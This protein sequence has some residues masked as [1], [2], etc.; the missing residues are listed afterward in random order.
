MIEYGIIIVIAAIQYLVY[1]VLDKT[2]VNFPKW[3]LLVILILGQIFIVPK[4]L[5]WAYS[6]GE[7]ECGMPIFALRMFFLIL[8]GSLNIVTHFAYYIKN[9]PTKR[10][11]I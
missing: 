7:N 11:E 9:N 4:L 2:G 3:L 5:I 10:Y 1:Q 6:L 8:G